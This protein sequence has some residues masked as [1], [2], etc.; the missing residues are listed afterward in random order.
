MVKY[1]T[2][3]TP[4]RFRRDHVLHMRLDHLQQAWPH[5]CSSSQGPPHTHKSSISPIIQ[6][7]M[8]CRHIQRQYDG[9]CQCYCVEHYC[10]RSVSPSFA[11]EMIN[12]T[13]TSVVTPTTSILDIHKAIYH[14]RH[15]PCSDQGPIYLSGV[16]ALERFE[17]DVGTQGQEPSSLFDA[18]STSGWRKWYEHFPCVS[19]C[20]S[21]AEQNPGDA[22]VNKNGWEQ[23]H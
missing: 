2:F 15:V 12:W 23:W 17:D 20:F 13:T 16:W 1:Q 21:N 5:E 14:H 7:F 22:V 3:Q 8:G 4:W 19:T 11:W 18:A 9:L 10:N 6:F